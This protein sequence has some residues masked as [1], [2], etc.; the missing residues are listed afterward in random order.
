MINTS[1]SAV[2]VKVGTS[3]GKGVVVGLGVDDGGGELGCSVAF[4]MASS[5]ER[6]S[7]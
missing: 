5:V 4:E 1:G 6:D 2:A 7:V 3:D